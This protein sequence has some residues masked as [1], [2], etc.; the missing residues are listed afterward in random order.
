[1][2]DL[3]TLARSLAADPEALSRLVDTTTRLQH[4]HD[5][6]LA[7]AT[8]MTST[9]QRAAHL[10]RVA[11]ALPTAPGQGRRVVLVMPPRHSKSET[12][13]RHLPAWLLGRFPSAQVICVSYSDDLA[14]SYG[15]DVRNLMQHERY[16]QIFPTRIDPNA[17]SVETFR[18]LQGGVYAARGITGSVVGMGA[19]FLILDDLIRSRQDA[20]SPA[21]RAATLNLWR[22][23]LRTRLAPGASVIA[24]GT[25]WHENDLLGTFI[26]SGEWEVVHLPAISDDGLA[27]WPE[28]FPI[29]ALRAIERDIGQREF[30]AQYQGR[31]APA[32]GAFYQAQWLHYYDP[33]ELR[34]RDLSLYLAAD[35]AYS[36]K[37]YNDATAIL[38]FGVSHDRK[39][40]LLDLWHQRTEMSTTADRIATFIRDNPAIRSILLESDPG[41][42]SQLGLLRDTLKRRNAYRVIHTVSAAGD[43]VAKSLASQGLF[44]SSRVL[45]PKGAHWLPTFESELLTFPSGKHDDI[46]DAVGLIGRNIDRIAGKPSKAPAPLVEFTI[47]DPRN[48]DD[49]SRKI[50]L[51]STFHAVEFSLNRHDYDS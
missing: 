27:L 20:E 40:Y 39:V 25:R 32:T 50:M 14:K 26:D 49:R 35:F 17:R 30:S 38:L 45:L 31:P 11:Q 10:E 6:L 33:E 9:Y 2:S 51:P 24:I 8:V 37:E 41:T 1:M 44:E 13:S 47:N 22:G 34:R 3:D 29:E 42:S 16:Q 7:F 5:D 48:P 4:A 43:K 18:T 36:S 21:M 15:F 19:D 46:V 23:S 28:R 12:A